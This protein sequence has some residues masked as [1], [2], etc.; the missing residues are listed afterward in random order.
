MPRPDVWLAT[1]MALRVKGRAT[2]AMI[3]AAARMPRPEADAALAAMVAAGHA[4]RMGESFAPTSAGRTELRALLAA[5]RIDRG[6]LAARYAAFLACDIGVKAAVTAWQLA[7]RGASASGGAPRRAPAGGDDRRR[8]AVLRR[9]GEAARALAAELGAIV[10]RLLAY[11][12]RLGAALAA[13]GGGD[14]RFVASPSVDS[15]HQVWFELHEDL[16]LTLGRERG[17]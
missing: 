2:A 17:A 14:T 6:A 4:L 8:L 1:L 13:L 5:E 11:P 12:D 16:L 15:L 9:A 3:A 7:T 10:P